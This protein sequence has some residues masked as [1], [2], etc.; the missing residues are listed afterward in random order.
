MGP[1]QSIQCHREVGVLA[2]NMTSKNILANF[3]SSHI[4]QIVS[5]FYKPPKPPKKAIQNYIPKFKGKNTP[6][7]SATSSVESSKSKKITKVVK[8]L[9]LPTQNCIMKTLKEVQPNSLRSFYNI[10]KYFQE[11]SNT[12][13]KKP[14]IE[15]VKR[16]YHCEQCR[17]RNLENSR[18]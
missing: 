4:R 9:C 11:P 12:N 14:A 1:S 8:R 17:K 18:S 2:R 7:S 3:T 13:S 16:V 5:P 6:S 10:L 15:Y